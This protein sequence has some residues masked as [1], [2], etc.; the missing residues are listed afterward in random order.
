MKV[1]AMILLFIVV[2]IAGWLPVSNLCGKENPSSLVKEVVEDYGK[3]LTETTIYFRQK[4]GLKIEHLP[5]RSYEAAERNMERVRAMLAKL[6]GIKE[7]DIPYDDYLSLAF[8]RW[9]LKSVLEY[10]GYFYFICPIAAYSSPI[11]DTN[12]FYSTF[13][14]GQPDDLSRYLSLTSQYADFIDQLTLILKEQVRRGI[15]LPKPALP[16]MAGYVKSLIQ[17]A[18]KSFLLVA[19]SRIKVK[20]ATETEIKA[21]Q[22]KLAGLI[23]NRVNPALKRM[24]AFIDGDYLAHAPERVGLWQY[25]GG[26][27]YYGLLLRYYTSLNLTPEQVHQ[28]GLRQIEILN[29]QLDEVRKEVGFK[30]ELTVFLN[31]I[32]N[33]KRF[34][35][36]SAE[37][38]GSRLMKYKKMADK[39]LPKFFKHFP[40]APCAVKRLNLRLEATMT[41]GFYEPPIGREKTGYYMYNASHLEKKSLLNVASAALILHE[42]QPGHHFQVVLQA[43]N[44]SLPGFRREYF[45]SAY[46]EGWAEYAAYLGHE[47]GIYNDPYER[48]GVIMQDMFMAVRLV[49]DTGMNYF[50]WPRKKAAAI[51]RK[52]SMISDREVDSETLRYSTGIPGQALAYKIGHMKMRELRRRAEKKLGD[53]FD[54]KEFH[55]VILGRGTLPLFLL[56]KHVDRY[57][58]ITLNQ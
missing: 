6:E 40:G 3:Y 28:T 36:K 16:K 31:Y 11:P 46:S 32:M 13:H 9:E 39:Q 54:I 33:D 10:H 22:K 20:D 5:G 57:I 51:M 55:H 29:K 44:K 19:A 35:P 26:K 47:M 49:V 15:V 41:Y 50:G 56:E 17:P 25:P 53:K 21:F 45:L 38:I 7:E 14:F 27:E 30:G 42:L 43:E 58:A 52:Y 18:E 24:T 48:A 2:L 37:Q 8:L 1:T 23:D 4:A 12:R 34:R